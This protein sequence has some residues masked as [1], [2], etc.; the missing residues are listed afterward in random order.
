MSCPF[1]VLPAKVRLRRSCLLQSNTLAYWAEAYFFQKSFV[2]HLVDCC[3]LLIVWTYLHLK[4]IQKPSPGKT[5]SRRRQ[6]TLGPLVGVTLPL[7]LILAYGSL[8]RLGTYTEK[9]VVLGR[10]EGRQ[11]SSIGKAHSLGWVKP[12]D[13]ILKPREG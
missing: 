6:S 1:L 9:L 12:R 2:K 10:I 3:S 13:R 8:M 4:Q 5:Y 11:G 7:N